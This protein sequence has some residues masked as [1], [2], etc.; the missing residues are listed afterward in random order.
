MSLTRHDQKQFYFNA[1][2]V[3]AESVQTIANDI[4]GVEEGADEDSERRN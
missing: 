3:T 2:G 1:L 4:H